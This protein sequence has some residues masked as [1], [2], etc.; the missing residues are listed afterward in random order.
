MVGGCPGTLASFTTKTGRHDI[1]KILLKVALKHQQSKSNQNPYANYAHRGGKQ[2]GGGSLFGSPQ[3]FITS[4]GPSHTG[5]HD[6]KVTVNLVSPIQQSTPTMG[7][8][9][10]SF[11]TC[12][13]SRVNH[14]CN[15]QSRA[16]THAVLVI[17]LYELLDP[18]T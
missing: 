8:Q 2:I 12:A 10:V 1:A 18:T 9:M 16:R 15:L 3:Q 17:G 4:V 5:G 11:I 6:E 13:V 7:T 14:F